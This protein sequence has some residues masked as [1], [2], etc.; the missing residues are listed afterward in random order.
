M[1]TCR[2]CP[3]E[4]PPPGQSRSRRRDEGFK[5]LEEGLA[6]PIELR[7][8]WRRGF[9]EGIL[10]LPRLMEL[11]RIQSAQLPRENATQ[12]NFEVDKYD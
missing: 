9:V 3:Q 7:S 5:G 2:S 11:A 6:C 8:G 12:A 4:G 10:I 1:Q